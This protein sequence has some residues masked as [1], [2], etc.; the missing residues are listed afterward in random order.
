MLL[1]HPH[2]GALPD[3]S[4]LLYTEPAKVLCDFTSV[5]GDQHFPARL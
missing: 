3:D 1:Q 5:P 4:S 2:P